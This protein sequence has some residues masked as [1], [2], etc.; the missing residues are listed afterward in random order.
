MNLKEFA[1]KFQD[2]NRLTVE[3]S[4]TDED[5]EIARSILEY[6]EDQGEVNA[7]ELCIYQKTR[8]RITAYDYNDEAESLDLFYLIRANSVL[9]KI[10]N[11]K[12][13]QGFNYLMSFYRESK[14][15]Q[16][17][18][19][20]TVSIT[21]EIAE[22]ARLIQSS[23]G[24]ISQL[25]L[26]IITD[27]ITE[28]DASGMAVESEDGSYIIEYNVWDM[29]RVYQ[30]HCIKTGK[31]K[32]EINFPIEYNAQL[33][34]LKMNDENPDV[35]AYMAI[36]PGVILAK[37]YLKYQ[38]ILLEK[39]V[40]TFLQFK[41]K[42]NKSIKKTLREEPEMFFAYN[43]GI[44]STAKEIETKKVGGTLYIT[45]FY[46][47]QIVNGGQTTA[48]IAACFKEKDFDLSK[49]FVPMKVSVIKDTE[50]GDNIIRNISINA[51]S[52]TA[53]KN[54]D[55]SANDTYLIELERLSRSEWVPN[56]KS[57]P[58]S[59]W[60]FERTRGQY[61]D[62]ISQLSGYYE[63]AF[64][65][66]YPKKHK[67]TKT[68]I[69]KYE[70]AWGMKP[71]LVCKGAEANYVAFVSNIKQNSPRVTPVYYRQMVAKAI[72]FNT[73]DDIVRA[74]KL[75]GYKA[76]ITA[77]IMSAI[78]FLSEQKL[79][80]DIIWEHQLVQTEIIDKINELIPL[81]WNHLVG[82]QITSNRG[83]NIPAWSKKADCWNRLKLSLTEITKFDDALMQVEKNDDGSPL[84]KEQEE[85]IIEAK[86]I[87][88]STWFNL[89][90]WAKTN[91]RLTPLECKMAF[92]YGTMRSRGRSFK[93]LNQALTALQL[94]K[95]AREL[96][97]EDI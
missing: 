50:N 55:F 67:I 8:A 4:N 83:N 78:A 44:S 3:M 64:K 68:D 85:K 92:N 7:P 91:N 35:D 75:G 94:L 47:W 36:I 59:K 46:D 81:I 76:Y 74:K 86:S 2:N 89:A 82:S 51:N 45:R 60:F 37:I 65:A 57:R 77:Y 27:G 42:V 72:L 58:N 56:G 13:Q 62:Q 43:N 52:Q 10:N 29:T 70:N 6:I 32:V 11:N 97:F 19:S 23:D 30:Q 12:I 69:A 80:L 71:F 24:H 39:N 28:P 88:P 31:T 16:L 14:N 25:R 49:V 33:Q 73:I 17:L 18:N 22:V 1:Q 87:E 26:Y 20:N 61:L 96:G 95:D 9:G 40:R 90:Q 66:E 41:G 93:S 38:Q 5:Q 84:N 34:C 54:S 53:I 48:S 79:N 63:R 21:D 15:G